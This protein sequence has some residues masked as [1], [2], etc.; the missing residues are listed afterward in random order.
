MYLGY[1]LETVDCIAETPSARM[2][3]SAWKASCPHTTSAMVPLF[4]SKIKSVTL[5]FPWNLQPYIFIDSSHGVNI[6]FCTLPRHHKTSKFCCRLT[7]KETFMKNPN[8]ACW[9]EQVNIKKILP[10]G[11]VLTNS[12]LE[13]DQI[14]NMSCTS[15]YSHKFH[16][17]SKEEII[18]HSKGCSCTALF[19]RSKQTN[20][21]KWLKSLSVKPFWAAKLFKKLPC[22]HWQKNR[23][24]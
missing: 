10:E 22:G 3:A 13:K 8:Q 11:P 21:K 12:M 6:L 1:L 15:K 7:K 24:N 23:L 9:N 18:E 2:T 19:S 4:P 16:L 17:V 20:L 5:L 14:A